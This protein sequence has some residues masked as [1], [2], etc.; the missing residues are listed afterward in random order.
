MLNNATGVAD[1]EYC[2]LYSWLLYIVALPSSI[3]DVHCIWW[4]YLL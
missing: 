4:L 2:W 1:A 3:N